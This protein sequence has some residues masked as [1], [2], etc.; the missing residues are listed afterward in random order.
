MTT[1]QIFQT[2]KINQAVE[3]SAEIREQLLV[4]RRLVK[5]LKERQISEGGMEKIKNIKIFGSHP[6]ASPAKSS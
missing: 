4:S 1:Q 3:F 5:N 6:D 2:E